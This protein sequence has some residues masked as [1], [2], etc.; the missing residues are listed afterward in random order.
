MNVRS[1][2]RG[3]FGPIAYIHGTKLVWPSK[4][5][6]RSWCDRVH[7]RYGFYVSFVHSTEFSARLFLQSSELGPP[8]P[9]TAGVCPPLLWFACVWGGHFTELMWPRKVTLRSQKISMKWLWPVKVTFASQF[10]WSINT[11]KP[12]RYNRPLQKTKLKNNLN[13]NSYRPIQLED[14][15][16]ISD[17]QSD[18]FP[19]F[20]CKQEHRV[21][22]SWTFP[23]DYH[24]IASFAPYSLLS[25]QSQHSQL[26]R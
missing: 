12:G 5:T 2:A 24:F 7:S 17:R 3:F 1:L 16:G 11:F 8:A 4:E 25:Q 10:E 15:I 22:L 26:D 13:C 6:L 21:K 9:S 19:T 14:R 23:L 18:H 20:P